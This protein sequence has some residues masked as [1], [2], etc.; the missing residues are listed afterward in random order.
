VLA[1]QT[2]LL[3]WSTAASNFTR[4]ELLAAVLAPAQAVLSQHSLSELHHVRT[5]WLSDIIVVMPWLGWHPIC[6]L[7]VAASEAAAQES[8][9]CY[10]AS[11]V[12][13]C[14]RVWGPELSCCTSAIG[15]GPCSV[16]CCHQHAMP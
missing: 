6:V 5:W 1:L 15:S 4:T 9:A 14:D 7:T 11:G 10:S 8:V 13:L 3:W 16:L 2:H 12:L